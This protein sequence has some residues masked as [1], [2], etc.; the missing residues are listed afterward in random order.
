MPKHAQSD[1]ALDFKAFG[2]FEIKDADKGE[3][4]AVVNTLNVVDRD[5]D[6]ILPGAIQDGAVVKLSAYDHDVVTKGAPPVG[7]GTISV[8]GDQV[9]MKGQYFLNTTRGRDAFETVK[10][11]GPN[12]EWSIGFPKNVKTAPMTK[13]WR[14]KGAERLIA[15]L[16]ILESSPVFLG[17]N[18]LTGT[19][20]AKSAVEQADGI[21]EVEPVETPDPQEITAKSEPE[22]VETQQ[23]TA[24]EI[25]SK[26]GKDLGAD[27][28]ARFERTRSRLPLAS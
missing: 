3:V 4:I 16:K 9:V 5:G 27:I 26:R 20:S 10:A 17:A 13:A 2:S 15:G 7:L 18:Y 25:E 14:E 19:V 28:Y 21:T 12:S 8:L 22:P 11:L 1:D 23:P 24:E 6:V